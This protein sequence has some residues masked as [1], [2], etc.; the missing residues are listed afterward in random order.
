MIVFAVAVLCLLLSA[1]CATHF[2]PEI[3]LHHN[4]FASARGGMDL[5]PDMELRIENA[6]YRPGVPRGGS[7]GFLGTEIARYRVQTNGT[8]RL[9]SVQPL[10]NR[11]R[12]EPPVQQLIP[13]R[14]RRYHDHRFYREVFL[15]SG[16]TR[17]SVL[18]GANT[19]EELHTDPHILCA[20]RSAH[21][22]VF[23]E[24]C[25]VSIEM[26]IFVNGAPRNVLW[27]SDVASVVDHPRRVE[28]LR[29]HNGRLIPIKLNPHDPRALQLPLLPGDRINWK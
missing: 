8:L 14:Q 9:L 17:G 2:H 22:T 15:P 10:K 20:K 24:E 11:P 7:H 18:I 12:G 19:Q 3:L 25:T 21:C 29:L 28:V 16:H 6:Y 27:D 1:S 4:G 5:H 13:R 26:E 23:P